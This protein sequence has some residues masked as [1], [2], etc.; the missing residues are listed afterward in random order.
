MTNAIVA[1]LNSHIAEGFAKEADVT[2]LFVQLGKLIERERPGQYLVVRF[3][4]NWVVHE[5][6]D[7]PSANPPMRGI[8]DAFEDILAAA[9]VGGDTADQVQQITDHLSLTALYREI[10]DLLGDFGFDRTMVGRPWDW[11]CF[12]PTLLA[13]LSDIDLKADG[14][15][16]HLDTL[17]VDSSTNELVITP[18]TAVPIRVQLTK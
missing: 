18:K 12:E 3:Y 1:K 15:Y 11:Q 5:K 13:I 8:L 4:R 2:Y 6:L 16:Q 10:D 14:A 9:H 17:K 7:R